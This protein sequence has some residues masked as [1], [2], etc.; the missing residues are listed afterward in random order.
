MKKREEEAKGKYEEASLEATE[1]ASEDRI[2]VPSA[3]KGEDRDDGDG[4]ET[5]AKT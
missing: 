2:G 1:E 5:A 3:S 4:D